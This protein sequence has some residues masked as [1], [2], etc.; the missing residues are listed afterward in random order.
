MNTLTE[1]FLES[2]RMNKEPPYDFEKIGA[3][4]L[5][6]PVAESTKFDWQESPSLD[7]TKKFWSSGQGVFQIEKE[8]KEGIQ[9]PFRLIMHVMEDKICSAG[10]FHSLA[11]AQEAANRI[12][13]F[14]LRSHINH[15]QVSGG[16]Y[17]AVMSH[18][19]FPDL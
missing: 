10:P 13:N 14:M 3:L 4:A 12:W 18:L 9:Y 11:T 5:A 8:L 15:S 17:A 16:G 2:D 7:G 1:I 6:K 19:V